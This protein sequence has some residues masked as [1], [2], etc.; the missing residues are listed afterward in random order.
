MQGSLLV[1]ALLKYQSPRVVVRSIL[2]M[3]TQEL[4]WLSRDVAG[5]HVI[6][7]FLTSPMVKLIKRRKLVDKLRVGSVL[8][9]V[10]T[11]SILMPYTG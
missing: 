3:E 10:Y 4:M 6:D 5:S 7:A 1:Q 9:D 2:S 8:S 11:A